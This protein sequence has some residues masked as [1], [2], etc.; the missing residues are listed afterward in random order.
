MLLFGRHGVGCG[1]MWFIYVDNGAWLKFKVTA[2]NGEKINR[3]FFQLK[4]IR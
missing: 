4:N 3:G 2:E 1:A